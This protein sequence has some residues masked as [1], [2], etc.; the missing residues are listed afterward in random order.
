MTLPSGPVKPRRT[1]GNVD[2]GAVDTAQ[3]SGCLRSRVVTAGHRSETL[4]VQ[5]GSAPASVT[6]LSQTPARSLKGSYG[7]G[8]TGRVV[9]WRLAQTQTP[10][11][12][13]HLLHFPSPGVSSCGENQS[14]TCYLPQ[15]NHNSP[16]TLVR[17]DSWWNFSDFLKNVFVGFREGEGSG[18]TLMREKLHQ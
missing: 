16:Q 3:G 2:G 4:S 7:T 15:I 9:G 10:H 13:N 14:Y 6:H 18:D 11:P 8:R 1:V 12:R 17:I 5:R